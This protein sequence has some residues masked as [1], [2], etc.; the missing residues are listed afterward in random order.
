MEE[1]IRLTPMYDDKP[2]STVNRPFQACLDMCVMVN[3]FLTIKE[4]NYYCCLMTLFVLQY[5]CIAYNR[6]NDLRLSS[7]LTFLPRGCSDICFSQ[8]LPK[9]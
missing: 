2:K 6:A 9:G 5:S 4:D 7:K 8:A 1:H 3:T